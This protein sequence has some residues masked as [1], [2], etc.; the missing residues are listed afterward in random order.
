M[1]HFAAWEPISPFNAK[2]GV[3]YSSSPSEIGPYCYLGSEHGALEIGSD[4]LIR[5]HSV[6]EGDVKIGAGFQCGH[7]ALIR[8]GARIGR[9]VKLGSYASLEGHVEL[10][11]DVQIG[12]RVQMGSW[13]PEGPPLRVGA[14]TRI[15]L[16]ARFLDRA[17]PPGG[18][19]APPLIGRDVVIGAGALILPGVIVYDEAMVAAGAIVDR[20]VS[21]GHLFKRDGSQVRRR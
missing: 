10:E 5:S 3:V 8:A 13:E 12:G 16:G 6:I 7:H 17:Q 2:G 18:I 19:Y 15:Y 4:A 21:P 14:R 9:N 20:D 1:E 11:Y